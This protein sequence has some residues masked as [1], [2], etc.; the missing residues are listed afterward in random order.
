[1]PVVVAVGH[2]ANRQLDATAVAVE[3]HHRLFD[4]APWRDDSL[5][6]AGHRVALGQPCVGVGHEPLEGAASP[7]AA[8]DRVMELWLA[9]ERS[10][11]RVGLARRYPGEVRHRSSG[12]G[13]G[14]VAAN[15]LQHGRREQVWKPRHTRSLSNTTPRERSM[16]RAQGF[17]Q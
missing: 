6:M 12:A 5:H 16:T 1:V 14:G 7:D 17:D 4:P 15:P 8:A 11:Q 3:R 10:E 2:D 13:V 9:G